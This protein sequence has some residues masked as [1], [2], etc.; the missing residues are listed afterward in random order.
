MNDQVKHGAAETDN[1]ETKP[2]QAALAKLDELAM[3]RDQIVR[4]AVDKRGDIFFELEVDQQKQFWA[5][6]GDELL[7]LKPENDSRVPLAS[8]FR[9]TGL[10][11]NCEIL[12]YR[13][14]SRIVLGPAPGQQGDIY[15]GYRKNRSEQARLKYQLAIPA[16]RHAD[17]DTPEPVA[18]KTEHECIRMARRH[19]QTPE[20]SKSATLLW[21]D[22]GWRLRRFQD[23]A[24]PR[25]LPV[26]DHADELAVLDE[27]ARRFRS[28]VAELPEP[29]MRGREQ[30]DTVAAQL[31]PL[32]EV[33]AHRDLHDRQFMV[34]G[35]TVTLLDFD[36]LCIADAALDAGNL[37]AHL[38]LRALQSGRENA[39][40]GASKCRKSLL[41]GLDRESDPGFDRKLF[42]YQATTFYRLALLYALRPR[43][44][45]LS[46]RLIGLGWQ[47]IVDF[48]KLRDIT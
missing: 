23:H 16:C 25:T 11:E 8:L 36:L 29:W 18:A 42:F 17:F 2:L 9:D 22:I 39:T 33:L 3:K 6:M 37:T 10:G 27:R 26:F 47:C 4:V 24:L 48:R 7:E 32:A 1:V 30:L 40:T 45:H 14:G 31:P 46:D 21:R 5:F 44:A 34:S 20:I 43:W 28:F 15:K 35:E 19:G 41:S 38:T 12:S 13:P